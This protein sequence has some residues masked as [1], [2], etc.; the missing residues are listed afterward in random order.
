M[1]IVFAVIG[2]LL[3]ACGNG[4]ETAETGLRVVATTTILGDVVRNVT[5]DAAQVEV[6]M[7]VG[8]DPHDFQASAAQ[9]RLLNEADLVVANGL[10]LE[11]GISDV[12]ASAEGDGAELLEIGPLLDPL[13][14]SA[15]DNDHAEHEEEEDVDHDH[16]EHDPHVW[17]DPRRMAQAAGLIASRLAEI[18]PSIDWASIAAPYAEELIAIDAEVVGILAAIPEED[19]KLVTNHDSMGYFAK[20]YGFSVVGTVIPGGSTL[21]EP[22]SEQLAELIDTIRSEQVRA[23]FV[24]STAPTDLAEAIAEE[25]E[26]EVAVVVLHTGSLGDPGSNTDTLA[27]LLVENARNIAAGLSR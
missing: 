8:A 4:Q 27:G 24:D 3:Q 19:R 13:P 25:I 7:P 23:I 17:M 14:P 22:S 18:D 2:L 15:I 10:G 21:G 16:G 1:T 20:R 26:E 5:G 6:L 11:E 12:L 9:V